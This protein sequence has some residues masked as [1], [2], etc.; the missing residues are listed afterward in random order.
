[1]QQMSLERDGRPAWLVG[2]LVVNLKRLLKSWTLL[3]NLY[4]G[5]QEPPRGIW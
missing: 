1:M 5:N 4:S 2:M 3:W